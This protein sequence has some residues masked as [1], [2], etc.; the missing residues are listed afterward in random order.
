MVR[1]EKRF[2][3][4]V[5]PDNFSLPFHKIEMLKNGKEI[6]GKML[7][8]IETAKYSIDMQYYAFEADGP[9]RK[10]L[11]ACKKAKEENPN[12]KIRILVDNSIEHLHN[13]ER[14]KTSEDARKRRD[15]TNEL[16]MS[17]R[18]EGVLEDVKITNSFDLKNKF[19]NSM[20]L[21]SNILH[22]DHKKLF[23]VDARDSETHPDATPK[24]IVG[25]ANVTR[26]H[27]DFWKDGARY[28]EGGNGVAALAEDFEDTEKSAKKWERV[29]AVQN[30]V[31]YWEKYGDKVTLLE[32][33]EDA[34]GAVVRNPQRRGYRKV[35]RKDPYGRWERDDVVATDSFWPKIFKSKLLGGHFATEET[36]AVIKKAQQNESIIIAS[37]YPGFFTLT[38]KMIRAS[39]RGVDTHLVI[40]RDNNHI[41]YNHHKIDTFPFPKKM[42]SWLENFIRGVAHKNLSYWE[43][44]LS[45]GEVHVH[46][47]TGEK[48]GLTGML[49][50]KGTQLIRL[51][52]S[53]RSIN[54][55]ANYTKGPISGLN[56]EIVVATEEGQVEND[57]MVPFMQ[58]LLK[59]SEYI[60]PVKS[61]RR[62]TRAAL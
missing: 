30:P 19:A 52:G 9:G 62:R 25:S 24:A 16:L 18:D 13:G 48:D 41:L 29:Y 59:D 53:V 50:F 28:F 5:S 32:A 43:E 56:R 26:H 45:R 33:A 42:P 35:I 39:K 3:P 34:V 31:E 23:L 20:R 4:P 6:F 57:P 11:E 36:Y 10:I 47:Y 40:P 49:H 58:E 38:N 37:P 61:Y 15:E 7:S 22:R 8:L 55:S 27:E 2:T 21:F 17:L 46:K 60:A 12:L 51:D 54:G 14:V 1:F 44:R